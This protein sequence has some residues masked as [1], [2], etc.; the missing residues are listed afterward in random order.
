ML[1]D[2]HFHTKY[3]FDCESEPELIVKM[4]LK[5]GLDNV[6]FTDHNNCDVWKKL[7][8]LKKKY[9]IETIQ[10][11]EIEVKLADGKLS[12]I[13]AYYMNEPIAKDIDIEIVLDK[14]KEQDALVAMAHP[15]RTKL[16][17]GN[18]HEKYIK[19][20]HAVETLN[21]RQVEKKENE[22]NQKAFQLAEKF[23]KAKIGGTDGHVPQ[24]VGIAVTKFEGDLREAIKKRKTEPIVFNFPEKKELTQFLFERIAVKLKK[25]LLMKK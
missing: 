13:L 9:G 21:G 2:L 24:E 19:K 1:F 15:Y 5:K 20:F 25:K 16:G 3:S 10:A 7:P 18:L 6:V 12:D 23:S 22:L 17:F 8:E 14:L 11:E 4:A